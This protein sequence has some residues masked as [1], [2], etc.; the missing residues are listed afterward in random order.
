VVSENHPVIPLEYG[1]GLRKSRIFREFF[2]KWC[3]VRET[4]AYLKALF[5]KFSE[6]F[7]VERV[8][9]AGQLL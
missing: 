1:A 8:A 5:L 4:I 7:G 3:R 2:G 6:N 9:K